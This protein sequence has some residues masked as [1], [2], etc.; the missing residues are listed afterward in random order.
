[1]QT[2]KLPLRAECKSETRETTTK[3]IIHSSTGIGKEERVEFT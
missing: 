1:M 3:L 2:P